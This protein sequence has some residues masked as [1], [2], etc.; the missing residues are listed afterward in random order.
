MS[1]SRIQPSF[2][3]A[4]EGG[5]RH[6]LFTGMEVLAMVEAGILGED[7]PLEL[8]DG[9]LLE[10]TPQ[11]PPHAGVV[12]ELLG[13]FSR[14]YG[15]RFSIRP[16]VPLEC[17]ARSLPEPD[18]AV[19]PASGNEFMRRHPRGNEALLVIEVARTSHAL[20]RQKA[21]IYARAA[22]PSYWIIDLVGR[23]VEVHEGPQPDG[24][25]ALV[26]IVAGSDTVT[27]PGTSAV[28]TVD[29]LLP[30]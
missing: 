20:D 19:V 25:Y 8:I 17:G 28:W 29:E 3:H 11:G 9:E 7:E 30:C 18:I 12:V 16:A 22:V 10:V 27:P 26:R 24:S 6:R 5:L 1:L 4:R 15:E 23:R 14:L 21:A 2:A 13:R